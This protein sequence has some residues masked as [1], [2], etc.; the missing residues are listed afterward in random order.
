MTGGISISED[1]S[2]RF[3]YAPNGEPVTVEARD[4]EGRVFKQTF[5]G[6]GAS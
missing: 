5:P 2:F 1:P 3:S 4:T 6:S